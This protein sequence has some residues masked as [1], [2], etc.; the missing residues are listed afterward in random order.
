MNKRLRLLVL[1]TLPAL[2]SCGGFSLN[3]IVEGKIPLFSLKII[4]NTGIVNLK[5]LHLKKLML[6][7]KRLCHLVTLE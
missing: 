5:M 7:L 2:A 6:L 3:Y 4:M 1:F